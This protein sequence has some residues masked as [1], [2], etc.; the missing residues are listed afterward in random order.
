LTRP[1]STPCPPATLIPITIARRRTC[2]R[3]K[4]DFYPSQRDSFFI[5]AWKERREIPLRSGKAFYV[6]PE[7]IIVWKVAY[8]AEG[9]SDKHVRDIRRML[10]VSSTEIDHSLLE[11]E[12]ERRN[13]LAV[14]LRMTTE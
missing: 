14:Y 2:L 13:L 1:I 3:Y 11:A 10:T 4:A 12:L 8:Y 9:G 5:W 7:Y 6:P